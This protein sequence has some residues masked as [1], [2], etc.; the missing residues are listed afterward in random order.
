[1]HCSPGRGQVH[2]GIA[3]DFYRRN[4]KAKMR[5]CLATKANMLRQIFACDILPHRIDDE[6]FEELF[7]PL[8]RQRC[9]VIDGGSSGQ[10]VLALFDHRVRLCVRRWLPQQGLV[11]KVSG[12]DQAGLWAWDPAVVK[13][14]FGP[15]SDIEAL[16]RS[17]GHVNPWEEPLEDKLAGSLSPSSPSLISTPRSITTTGGPLGQLEQPRRPTTPTTPT[18]C[19]AALARRPLVAEGGRPPH[20]I[21]PPMT[22]QK[23]LRSTN[24]YTGSP[25]TPSRAALARSRHAPPTPKAALPSRGCWGEAQD[26]HPTPSP[27]AADDRNWAPPSPKTVWPAAAPRL[28][29]NAAHYA[30]SIAPSEDGGARIHASERG[31]HRGRLA[32]TVREEDDVDNDDD[33][34]DDDDDS[35]DLD[36]GG[37]P[38]WHASDGYRNDRDGVIVTAPESV[39]PSSWH[40]HQHQHQQQQQDAPPQTGNQPEAYYRCDISARLSPA[41]DVSG[42]DEGYKRFLRSLAVSKKARR[43]VVEADV[44]AT[45][46]LFEAFHVRRPGDRDRGLSADNRPSTGCG[47]SR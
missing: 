29:L 6:G 35:V 11:T 12:H 38:G 19:A 4:P 25:G 17:L 7:L 5:L 47:Q 3:L 16:L 45:L 24:F 26:W 14:W 27:A 22:P 37:A 43:L 2:C 15:G 31:Y 18:P 40:R 10:T 1:M 44:E 23:Q 42:L 46:S 13:R 36:D 39:Q 32:H 21:P 33:E 9:N 41:G 34:D 28:P 8:V 30:P 20:V